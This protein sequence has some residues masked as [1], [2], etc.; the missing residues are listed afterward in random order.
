[1]VIWRLIRLKFIFEE[2]I[3][4]PKVRYLNLFFF[5]VCLG[6]F[7]GCAAPA[8][9]KLT[10][11]PATQPLSTLVSPT[12]ASLPGNLPNPNSDTPPNKMPAVENHSLVSGKVILVAAYPKNSTRVLIRL[13][14]TVSAPVENFR[15]FTSD[16]VG[17]EIEILVDP[18]LASSVKAGDSIQLKVS[19]RGD[20]FG[21]NFYGSDLTAN[22]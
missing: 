8:S 4:N 14:V 13:S 10:P 3:L 7:A 20:E 11:I 5:V 18:A 9:P 6:S 1:V 15:S 12:Q 21:G 17:Q 19:Y 2:H 22:P 16:K